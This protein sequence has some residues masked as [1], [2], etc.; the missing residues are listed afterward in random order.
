MLLDSP[1]NKA[2]V[3]RAIFPTLDQYKGESTYLDQFRAH[4]EIV[5]VS[6]RTQEKWVQNVRLA[7]RRIQ[8]PFGSWEESDVV[9]YLKEQRKRDIAAE[10]WRG[11]RFALQ[12][13]CR[14][15]QD[16]DWDCFD[17]PMRAPERRTP[18]RCID[19]ETWRAIYR[20]IQSPIHG[21][22]LG[23]CWVSG[24]RISEACRIR[25]TDWE[26]RGML[27]VLGKGERTRYV[28]VP[29]RTLQYL[30]TLWL[31]HRHPQYLFPQG[32]M[33]KPVSPDVVAETFRRA[34]ITAGIT[35]PYGT[36]ALRHGY[37]TRL[38]DAG[39]SED[40]IRQLLGHAQ[41]ETTRRYLHVTPDQQRR[42]IEVVTGQ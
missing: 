27:R 13:F 38:Y 42:V 3:L 39:I 20:Q 34:R 7:R 15:F 30:R 29:P 23:M 26:E 14:D 35:D 16:R 6:A 41:V 11:Y 5:G 2:L 28:P 12:A 22:V 36:H 17:K 33:T 25:V 24:L 1:Q 37:A 18:G 4:L 32:D 40:V 21:A 19:A 10:T 8:L 9:N 31:A